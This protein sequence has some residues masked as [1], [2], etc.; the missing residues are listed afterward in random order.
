[1]PFFSVIIPLYNKEKYIANTLKTVINQTFEDFEIII[2]NDGSTD[3][4]IHEIKKIK[5]ARIRVI[6]QANQGLSIARNTGFENA[7]SDYFALIDA[8]DFWLP[9][10]LEQLYHLIMDFPDAG[11]YSTGYTL[12]K[13]ES[14]YH[15]A[16][17]N[18]LSDNFRGI[19]PNFFENSL[20]NCVAW[21]GSVCIPKSTIQTIGD[22]D[23]EIYSE[24]DTDLYIRIALKFEVALDDTSVS[25]VY[26][27]T[28]DDNMS[29][30]SQKK[31]I[32]KLLDTYKDIEME[33]PHL[34]RYV[35]YNRFS[36]VVHFRLAG[37][38]K[39]AN[40]IMKDIDEKNLTNLQRLLLKLP[41]R[42]LRQ[43]YFFKIKWKLNALNVFRPNQ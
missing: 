24:Q 35:D 17:F 41:Y 15:R 13:S 31:N 2:V 37:H 28:M 5:D 6:N 42:I 11:L 1:M 3:G 29:N 34:K 23:P 27:K 26:N 8:D 10:H 14:I 43:L 33:D 16:K 22:F 4:G 18:G 40:K 12:K 20:G 7:S 19:V 25:A 36:N 9:H 30:F 21:V 32:P 39:S 38:T